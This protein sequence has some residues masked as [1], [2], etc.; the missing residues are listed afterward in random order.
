MQ[1]ETIIQVSKQLLYYILQCMMLHSYI[2]SSKQLY[3][4]IAPC[5]YIKLIIKIAQNIIPAQIHYFILLFF[6]LSSTYKQCN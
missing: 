6:D 4:L 2:L 1:L 3:L 5:N